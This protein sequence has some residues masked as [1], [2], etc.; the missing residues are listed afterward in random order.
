MF[1]CVHVLQK[2]AL[3]FKKLDSV[4]KD[5]EVVLNFPKYQ[6]RFSENERRPQIVGV[7]KTTSFFLLN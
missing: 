5:I 7:Q 4:L 3:S 2:Q 6:P 1:V